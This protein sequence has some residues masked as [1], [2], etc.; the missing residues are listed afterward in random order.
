MKVK[1]AK[2]WPLFRQIAYGVGAVGLGG[3]ALA[4]WI[5]ADEAAAWSD[6]IEQ[7]LG[8]A[9]LLMAGLYVDRGKPSGPVEPEPVDEP[10]FGSN[11]ATAVIERVRA[12]AAAGIDQFGDSVRA[13]LERRL[14]R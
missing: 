10:E 9:A 6:Q 3:S 4:G 14:E 13:E 11:S 8:M 2:S 1:L 12:E 5:T 7:V